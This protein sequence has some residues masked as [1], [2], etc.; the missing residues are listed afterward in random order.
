M[1]TDAGCGLTRALDEDELY[2]SHTA[3]VEGTLV[4]SN[5]AHLGSFSDGTHQTGDAGLPSVVINDPSVKVDFVFQLVNAGNASSETVEAALLGTAEQLIGIGAGSSTGPSVVSSI[6]AAIPASGPW[7]LVLKGVGKLWDWLTTNCDGPVA[8]DRLSGPRFAIDNWTDDDPTGTISVI[9]KGYGGLDSP[10]G[11]GSN[12]AYRVTWFVQHW[13]GWSEVGTPRT[14]SSTRRRASPSRRTTVPCTSSEH[15]LALESPTPERSAVPTGRS[16]CS[17]GSNEGISFTSTRSPQRHQLRRPAPSVRGPRRRLDLAAGPH[18]RRR[19]VG[20][21][22][23][24]T[25]HRPHHVAAHRD[26]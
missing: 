21:I 6:L 7:A 24:T 23:T 1:G 5:S 15:L 9:Q 22:R 14:R 19:V 18:H 13:R 3:H 10:D 26:H 4:A 8:V 25:A 2:L 11:C 12:S 16:I 20:D 17:M